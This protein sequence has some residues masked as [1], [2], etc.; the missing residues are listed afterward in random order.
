MNLRKVIHPQ[1]H[2]N[3]RVI[4]KLDASELEIGSIGMQHGAAWAWGIV[5][6]IPMRVMR[7]QGEGKDRRDCMR[8]FRDAWD[9]FAVGPHA[10]SHSL[11]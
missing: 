7:T 9:R 8:Q 3:Y 6:V 2:E 4:L 11:H 1:A 10:Q 5:T